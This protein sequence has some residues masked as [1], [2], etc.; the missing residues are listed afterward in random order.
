MRSDE[1]KLRRK[2]TQDDLDDHITDVRL[3]AALKRRFNIEQSDKTRS[4]KNIIDGTEYLSRS[5]RWSEEE[6][7][8]HSYVYVYDSNVTIFGEEESDE[9][10]EEEIDKWFDHPYSEDLENDPSNLF[11]EGDDYFESCKWESRFNSKRH[12]KVA[13][14]P[15]QNVVDGIPESYRFVKW[16]KMSDVD[17]DEEFFIDDEEDMFSEK[18]ID[19]WFDNPRCEDLESEPDLF[20]EDLY[21]YMDD[22]K[23]VQSTSKDSIVKPFKSI[24]KN[25]TQDILIDAEISAPL[26]TMQLSVH[27]GKFS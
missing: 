13:G 2:R 7:L 19:D 18:D 1:S 27:S 21:L 3:D 17:D 6:R 5:G 11:E 15:W 26:Q 23:D 10:S 22:E 16:E 14:T 24:L 9:V 8:V 20:F 25:K 4:W 12:W